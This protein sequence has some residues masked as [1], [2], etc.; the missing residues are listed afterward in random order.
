MLTEE[1][2]NEKAN[3]VVHQAMIAAY[4]VIQPE[5]D[6]I[7][8]DILWH[9]T[10]A[11][12]LKAILETR[13]IYASHFNYL[14]DP[15]ENKL[16][17]VIAQLVAKER[18]NNLPNLKSDDQ[19]RSVD[20]FKSTLWR[21]VLGIDE[22][23]IDDSTCVACFSESGDLLGQWRAYADNCNGYAVGLSARWLKEQEISESF[24]FRLVK[25]IYNPNKQRELVSKLFDA[26]IATLA[27]IFSEI[28]E[29]DI[30]DF[31]TYILIIFRRV[32]AEFSPR[33]KHKAYCDEREWRL[34]TIS[35][36]IEVR[37]AKRSFVQYTVIDL[38]SKGHPFKEVKIGPANNYTIEK[39]AIQLLLKSLKLEKDIEVSESLIPLK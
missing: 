14:N 33:I 6:V 1:F 29:E 21:I 7:I 20:E 35:K 16:F 12:S 2:K 27:S 8:P 32:V 17:G 4:E 22:F 23:F 26:S 24:P 13:A 3:Q 19:I 34:L 36:K 11:S 28:Q 31:I 15:T 9:Y 25:I 10:N 38:N 5:K 30:G 18:L 37:E 39:P